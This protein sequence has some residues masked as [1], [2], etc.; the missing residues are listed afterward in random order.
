MLASPNSGLVVIRCACC[1]RRLSRS[2]DRYCA[3]CFRSAIRRSRGD[4]STV[5]LSGIYVSLARDSRRYG[6][7]RRAR[8]MW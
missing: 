4:V 3:E 5:V 8:S 1:E 2:E 7:V 6:R